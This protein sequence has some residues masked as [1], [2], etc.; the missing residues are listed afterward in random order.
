M[1]DPIH[2]AKMLADPAFD[3]YK[4]DAEL[5]SLSAVID[6]EPLGDRYNFLCA[7]YQALMWAR[8]PKD[9]SPPTKMAEAFSK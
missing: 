2:E 3:F 1:S 7:S 5:E 8:N 6:V 9:H 4:L